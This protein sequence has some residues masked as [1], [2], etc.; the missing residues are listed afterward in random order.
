MGCT[1]VFFGEGFEEVEAL[2]VVDLLR[3]AEGNVKMIGIAGT[4]SVTGS[5]G[6]SIKMDG[7]M[8]DVTILDAEMLVLP[9]GGEGT[10]NLGACQPLTSLLAAAD[11]RKL[12][13]GAICA[14]PS[15][16]GDMGILQGR[17]AVCYPGFEDRL[18]GAKVSR[19]PVAE[20]GHI[21]TSRGV[22]TAIAFSLK[23]IARIK[24]KDEADRIEKAIIYNV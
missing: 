7:S 16:L 9:G 8:V 23:L 6:I 14:A 1:Y 19:E 3:R 17:R 4:E 13:I 5:H 22:G 2:T 15:I 24:G 12:P 18:I 21:I 10:N 11:K 20:D